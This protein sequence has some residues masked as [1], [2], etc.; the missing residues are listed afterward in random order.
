VIPCVREVHLRNFRSIEHA[1]VRLADL[2]VLV[3]SNGSGKTNFVDALAFVRECLSSSVETALGRRGGFNQLC[4]GFAAAED[5]RVGLR[6]VVELDEQ[7]VAD[8]AFELVQRNQG[9]VEVAEERCV[10]S[11]GGEERHQFDVRGGAFLEPITGL[12]SAIEPDRL[13]LYAASATRQFRPLYDFLTGIR[14]YSIDP[15]SLRGL[16]DVGTGLSLEPDGG[17]AAAVFAYLRDHYPE[18]F[19]R[20]RSVLKSVVPDI[21]LVDG[22]TVGGKQF[23][24]FAERTG[25]EDVFPL[26]ASG[27]SDGTL[28]MLGLLLAV[29]QP[30]T[31]TV[32][33]IEEPEATIHPAAVDAVVAVLL[34]ASKRSQVLL[35]THSADLLDYK[36]IPE[37]A[38]RVVSRGGGHGTAVAPLANSSREAIRK[39]LYSPGELLR[40]DELNPDIAAA[41]SLSRHTPLFG[42]PV[43]TV[44]EA[45]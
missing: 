35:T 38:I 14:P 25:S 28:R 39:R 18:R 33:L 42:A 43:R 17:N 16:R 15:E 2:T 45:A 7:T 13:A 12:Q 41:E 44:G 22:A 9:E 11:V 30:S 31:A 20:V 8:Y 1:V 27:V 6:V 36:H 29:Y 37:G 24:L 5:R 10:I 3:G 40:A 26:A 32:L 19:Q 34:D 4:Y 23:L 21:E